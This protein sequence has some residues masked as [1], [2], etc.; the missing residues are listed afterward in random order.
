MK[1]FLVVALVL[2]AFGV[3]LAQAQ[4]QPAGA[5]TAKS[6]KLCPKC[7]EANPTQ[8]RFCF[9]CGTPFEAGAVPALGADAYCLAKEIE[10][11]QNGGH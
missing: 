11:L 5:D 8:A 10:C 4:P 9:S 6:Y 2:F 7:H 3:C 1:D